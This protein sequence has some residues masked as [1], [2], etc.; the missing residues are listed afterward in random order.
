MRGVLALLAFPLALHAAP[1]FRA[2]VDAVRVEALVLDH[3]R[4][5]AGLTAADFVVTDDG[6]RQAI[7]VRPLA[8]EPIDVAI[9]LD[10]SAS[11]RG[12]RLGLLQSGVHA[13]ITQLTAADRTTLLTFDHAIVLGPRDVEPA[14]IEARLRALTAQGRTSLIDAVTTAL[15]WSA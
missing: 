9:A 8:R 14:A 10:V 2:S 11:V 4:P 13:L 5:V 1:Q 7:A 3:G 15:V 12:S 6:V